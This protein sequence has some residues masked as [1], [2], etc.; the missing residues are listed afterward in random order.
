MLRAVRKMTAEAKLGVRTTLREACGDGSLRFGALKFAD[1]EAPPAR[2]AA[3]LRPRI[4]LDLQ[5]FELFR[6]STTSCRSK[7][8]TGASISTPNSPY[9]AGILCSIQR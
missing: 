5:R 6:I 9:I 1:A 2:R 4:P 3:G 7:A 8:I